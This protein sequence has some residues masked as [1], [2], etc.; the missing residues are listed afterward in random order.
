MAKRQHSEWENM[1]ASETTGKRIISKI[2][3]QLI[4]LN[5]KINNPIKMWAEDVNRHFSKDVIKKAKRY[6]KRYTTS[7]IIGLPWWYSS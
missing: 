3:K 1:F 2:Y 5:I 7:L 6:M 4:Q